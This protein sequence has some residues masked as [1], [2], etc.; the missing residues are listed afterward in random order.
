MLKSD[1][2]ALH[3]HNNTKKVLD[4]LIIGGGLSGVMLAHEIQRTLPS[5]SWNLLEARPMLGG[6]LAND[7]QGHWIDMGGAWVWPDHQPHMRQLLQKRRSLVTTFLQPDDPSST[8]IDGGAVELVQ[9]LAKDL[10]NDN[11]FLNS[12]VTK[13]RLVNETTAVVDEQQ[14]QAGEEQQP[15]LQQ[16]V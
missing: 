11:L 5:A 8:R 12:P 1:A 7:D 10:P 9:A 2:S 16:L 4:I 14:C 6:R 13:C 3:I 15:Q